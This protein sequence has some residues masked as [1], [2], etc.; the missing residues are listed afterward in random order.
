MCIADVGISISKYCGV[1]FDEISKIIKDS[2][3]DK[4]HIVI[5]DF[6]RNKNDISIYPLGL[7]NA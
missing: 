6:S 2:K 7:H 3:T 1:G 4:L 5:E